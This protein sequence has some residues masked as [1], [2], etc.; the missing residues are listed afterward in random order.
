LAMD[1]TLRIGRDSHVAQT[2]GAAP[3]GAAP[4]KPGC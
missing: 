3:E 4:D 2:K 1:D